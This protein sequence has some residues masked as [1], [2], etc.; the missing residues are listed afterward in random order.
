ME[1]TP[2]SLLEK[3]RSPDRQRAWE[4]FVYLSTPLLCQWAWRLGLTG[5]DAE[6]LVQDVFVVLLQKLPSFEYDPQQRF[7]AWLWTVTV[8]KHRER[9]RRRSDSA[10]TVGQLVAE[11][12]IPDQIDAVIEADFQH[13]LVQRAL[14]LMQN[15]FQS[16]T[17]RAFWECT[18]NGRP[19]VEVAT[20]LQIGL[21][22]V[23]AAKS[24]VLR[25]LRAELKE[26]LD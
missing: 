4:R 1:K 9:L 3:L 26:L 16:A 14:Q 23:Y 20:E 2:V 6:D 15:E 10:Q 7:R 22:S 11:P 25:R 19:A 17:W 21:D 24:R 12:E 8:N 18:V 13:Y 5:P